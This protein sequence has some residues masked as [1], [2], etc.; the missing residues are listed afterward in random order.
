MP[1]FLSIKDYVNSA[2][3]LKS[4]IE[5]IDNAINA[6]LDKL[7]DTAGNADLREYQLDDGQTRIRTNYATASDVQA[8]IFALEKLKQVYVNRLYGRTTKLIDSKNFI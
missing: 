4:K 5:K 6:L 7:L 3:D 2:D 8:G 1:I